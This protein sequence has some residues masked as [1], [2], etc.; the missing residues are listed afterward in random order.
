MALVATFAASARAQ[1][2][3]QADATRFEFRAPDGCSSAEDFAARVR[4]RSWRIRLE[5]STP[6]LARALVVEIQQP[7]VG[8]LRGIVTVIEPDGATRTRQLKAAS[9]EEAVDALSLIA[10]VTLDP[11]AMLGE[12]EPQSTPPPE[13]KPQPKPPPAALP[14][15]ASRPAP[16]ARN[17][18]Y[19]VSFGLEAT[20]LF[21]M[22][23]DVAPGGTLSGAFEISPYQLLSP[24]F[25]LAVTHAERRSSFE[26]H[27]DASFA[28]TLPALDV[29]PVR[30]GPRSFGLRPCAFAS[31]GLLRVS[32]DAVQ[33]EAH[34]RFYGQG[35]AALL[36]QLRVSE[37]FEIIADGRAGLPFVRDDYG[38][39]R[40]TLFTTPTPGFSASLGAAGGFP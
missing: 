32:G 16:A 29:C 21:R 26:G 31:A 15:P 6:P 14:P 2:P 38:F 1:S 11:D 8:A 25:R 13:P 10:T 9:C 40:V 7:S 17:P 23:P 18:R 20:L 30:L 22:A 28:F 3:A 24:L 12:P 33:S 34:S 39:D 5:P 37:A 27:G 19:R 36:A 35:G 4:R